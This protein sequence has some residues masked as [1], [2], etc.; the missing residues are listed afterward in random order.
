LPAQ[1]EVV[2]T[3][4]GEVIAARARRADSVWSRVVGLL[5]KKGLDPD[6]ALVFQPCW[7][8]HTFF[9]R[10]RLDVIFLDKAGAVRKVVQGLPAYRFA[11]SRGANVTIEMSAGV[12]AGRDLAIGDVLEVRRVES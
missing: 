10:F 7:S 5:G 9:M 11:A 4:T 8:I 1:Y 3:R 2:N 12:L 6:E